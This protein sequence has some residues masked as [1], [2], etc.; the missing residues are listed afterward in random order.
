MFDL[1][2]MSAVDLLG[3]YNELAIHA[4]QP[5]K[6]SKFRTKLMATRAIEVLRAELGTTRVERIEESLKFSEADL[7]TAVELMGDSQG[8]TVS[9]ATPEGVFLPTDEAFLKAGEAEYGPTR[10]DFEEELGIPLPTRTEVT[11]DHQE[12]FLITCDYDEATLQQ[13]E[14]IAM[15][16]A[17]RADLPVNWKPQPGAQEAFLKAGEAFRDRVVDHLLGM[18]GMRLVGESKSKA[19]VPQTKPLLR[20]RQFQ[21]GSMI[22][23]AAMLHSWFHHT[24]YFYGAGKLETYKQTMQEHLGL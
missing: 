4:R 5:R 23:F 3:Y 11:G 10:E 20:L 21:R 9:I 19:E 7:Q 15:K 24:G 2:N 1:T 22:G 18:P 17:Q 14:F 12:E 8:I 6:E 13:Q 16:K